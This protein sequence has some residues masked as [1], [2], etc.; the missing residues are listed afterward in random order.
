[1]GKVFV[2]QAMVKKYFLATES[3]EE[4]GYFLNYRSISIAILVLTLHLLLLFVALGNESYL[5]DDSIQYLTLSENLIRYGVYSQSYLPPYVPDLQRTPGYPMFLVICGNSISSVLILQHLMVLLCGLVLFRIMRLFFKLRIARIGAWIWL[6][7]PYPILMASMV[8]SEI[9]F[10][11]ALLLGVYG[12]LKHLQ[13]GRLSD[14]IWG[15]GGLA[16]AVYVRPVALP[17]LFLLQ[18]ILLMKMIRPKF[19]STVLAALKP[20]S[21]PWIPFSIS[22]V[23][24]FLLIGP[25]IIRNHAISGRWVLSSMGDIGMVHGRLGG[26]EAFRQDLGVGE[27]QLF[28]LGDS[29]AIQKGGLQGYRKYYSV[30]QS[31]ETELFR[32]GTTSATIDYYLRHPVDGVLFQGKSLL[33]MLQGVGFGWS[34]HLTGSNLAAYLLAGLQLLAN[35]MMFSGCIWA[36]YWFRK[37]PSYLGFIFWSSL[38]ILW[39]SNSAWADGRYRMVV[40][41]FLVVLSGRLWSSFSQWTR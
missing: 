2:D 12:T 13:G 8:L 32:S 40:D 23:I 1:M 30:K 21:R 3:N 19:G 5:T 25:W 35:V 41:P 24:L 16:L 33:A 34:V 15:L 28:R 14:L 27:T 38:L 39:I 20:S 11:M 9:P 29:L 6:L 37:W 17:V 31:H 18:S 7:Q 10:M 26:L 4:I 22:L 36:L